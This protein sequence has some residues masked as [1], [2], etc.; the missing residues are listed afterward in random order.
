MISKLAG[1]AALLVFASTAQAVSLSGSDGTSLDVSRVAVVVFAQGDTPDRYA[2]TAQARMETILQDNGIEVIDRDEV[3]KLKDVWTLLEDPAYFVTAEAFLDNAGQYQIDGIVRLY[4][5]TD[6][7]RSLGG[8]H[9]ATAQAD[10][11]FVGSDATVAA[12]TSY[13]M[14]APGR[15]PSDGLTEAAALINAVQRA[16]DDAAGGLNLE[17]LE[18]ATPRALQLALDGPTAAPVGVPAELRV[19]ASESD[20]WVSAAELSDARWSSEKVTC[21]ALAPAGGLG[22][23]GTK[24]SELNRKRRK[25]YGSKL[26]VVDTTQQREIYS[27]VTNEV[28]LKDKKHRG[29]SAVLDCLFLGSWR[30]LAATTGDVL[31]LWDT[32]RGVAMAEV[33]LPDGLDEAR[34]EFLRD[35]TGDFVNVRTGKRDDGWAYRIVRAQ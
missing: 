22:V 9:S 13:P 31:S 30:Y 29:D 16:I 32:E 23:V 25:V 27:F 21:T 26:H 12:F 17:L 7:A 11:R 20:P 28:G 15:P 10:T 24:L 4:L 34:L 2:R 1:M 18:T 19:A 33:L 3:D 8:F 14:G 5:L 6:T 35:G